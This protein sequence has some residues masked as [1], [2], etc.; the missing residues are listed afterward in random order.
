[1]CRRH[2]R[3]AKPTIADDNY[4]P[5]EAHMFARNSRIYHVATLAL[6]SMI[7]GCSS[8]STTAAVAAATPAQ[9]V[10]VAGSNALVGTVGA[11]LPPVQVEVQD[12]SSAPIAGQTVT[13][14]VI[15]GGGAVNAT[16]STTDS[17]GIASV[18]WTLGPV[19]GTDSL[20][21][22]VNG[23]SLNATISATATQ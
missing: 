4:H 10:V 15:S 16:S 19:A 3:A 2:L 13:W 20:L 22:A 14:T 18:V 23:T 7:G 8:D 21:A 17:N 5:V 1:V 12:A 6:A 9:V 11:V